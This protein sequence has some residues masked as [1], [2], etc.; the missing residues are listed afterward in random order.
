MSLRFHY[1][2]LACASLAFGSC[3]ISG[4]FENRFEHDGFESLQSRWTP[5]HLHSENRTFPGRQEEVGQF[6]GREL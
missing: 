2:D 1:R 5:F 3:K 4:L 6:R